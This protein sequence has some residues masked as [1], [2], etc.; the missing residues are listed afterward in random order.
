MSF[1]IDLNLYNEIASSRRIDPSVLLAMTEVINSIMKTT[2][3]K[4]SIDFRLPLLGF[5]MVAVF[6]FAAF[7]SSKYE[8]TMSDASASCSEIDGILT[9]TQAVAAWSS[10]EAGADVTLDAATHEATAQVWNNTDCSLPLSFVSHKM[11]DRILSHETLIQAVPERMLGPNSAQNFS[12]P[13]ATCMTHASL[14][15]GAGPTVFEDIDYSVVGEH[16]R[17]QEA[18]YGNNGFGREDA[19][20]NFCGNNTVVSSCAKVGVHAVLF[21]NLIRV[22]EFT[23]IVAPLGF[24][25]G[26]FSPN[27]DGVTVVPTDGISAQVSAQLPGEYV[28][29][30]TDWKNAS[31]QEIC[32]LAGTLLTVVD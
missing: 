13:V 7:V 21:K 3:H 9:P 26:Y 5:A 15:Y 25:N 27:K 18:F 16:T 11:Y 12:V 19:V 6:G 28:I 31:S 10:G 8:P 4:N 1:R 22:G 23:T 17:L 2:K 32:G 30:G 20:G 14:W 29:Y 24:A